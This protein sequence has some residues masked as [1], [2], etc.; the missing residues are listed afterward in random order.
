VYL[1]SNVDGLDNET[2]RRTDRVDVLIHNPLHNSRLAR[3]VKAPVWIR[4]GLIDWLDG[5]TPLTTSTHASLCPLALPFEV[6]RASW[7]ATGGLAVV[8][9]RIRCGGIAAGEINVRIQ[10][11]VSWKA[12]P[13]LPPVAR[14]EAEDKKTPSRKRSRLMHG[15]LCRG[16]TRSNDYFRAPIWLMR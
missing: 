14:D 7:S 6:P 12:A 9:S 16:A 5:L 3:I 1:P 15:E 4:S 2:Q 11:R 13:G 8:G 10:V